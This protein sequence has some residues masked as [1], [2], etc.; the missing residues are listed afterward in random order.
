MTM[1]DVEKQ[2]PAPP[3]QQPPNKRPIVRGILWSLL[4]VVV[5]LLSA[6]IVMISTDKG[7]R[8]LLDRVLSTQSMIKYKYESGNLLQ[9]IILQ[10]VHVNL[11]DM[12]I[13][14][15][16]ADVS[17]GW[18]A[19]LKK[20]IHLSH[21]NVSNLQIISHAPPSDEPFKFSEIKLPFVLRLDE[22]N[23][24]H[25]RYQSNDSSIDFNDIRLEDGLWSGTE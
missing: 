5:G 22:V 16:R 13:K 3:Q 24:D 9:G 10:Q 14:V 18:R 23:L 4:L 17:L 8:F 7:S 25:L 15:D 21:A 6:L 12:E 11:T 19:I 20:E 1:L 2:E